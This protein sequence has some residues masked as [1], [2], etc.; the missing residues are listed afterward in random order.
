[1]GTWGAS[2]YADDKACDLRDTV[3][4][5][6]KVPVPGN[7]LL[8][9]LKETCGDCD[10][11]D[12]EG[13]LFWLVTADQFERRGIECHEV[14]SKALSIIESGLDL[15]WAKERGADSTFLRK[16]SLV[17][18]DLA[19]RLKSPREFRPRTPPRNPPPMVITTG[20]IYSFPTMNG[21]AHS[22]Y[23][24]PQDGP[25]KPDGWGALVALATGR[26]FDWIPWVAIASLE[27]KTNR[28]ITLEEASRARLIFHSQTSGAGRFIP[29][30]SHARTMGLELLGQVSLDARLVKPHISK[31]SVA[32]AVEYD[33]SIVGGAI[34]SKS[35]LSP[36]G[37]KLSSLIRHIV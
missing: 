15:V 31:W 6:C 9:L 3:S 29:K 5:I 32:R 36:R 34:S 10:P 27:L 25:F 19:K 23:R 11:A 37:P 4:L 1:M 2:I 21:C 7:R 33:W 22:P 18:K 20:G 8:D 30:S 28:K 24:L 12:E 13:G 26:A 17:L 16:R 14:A 35:K